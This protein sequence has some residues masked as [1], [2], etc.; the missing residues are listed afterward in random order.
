MYGCRHLWLVITNVMWVWEVFVGGILQSPT[1][2]VITEN[3]H[4]IHNTNFSHHTSFSIRVIFQKSTASTEMVCEIFC[5]LLKYTIV[6]TCC[7]LFACLVPQKFE[8]YFFTCK[9]NKIKVNDSI[10]QSSSVLDNGGDEG[11]EI[12][13]NYSTCLTKK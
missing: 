5:L 11:E 6:H 1:K 10:K 8:M 9:W 7:Q 3:K 4:Y 2:N 13:L 12:H